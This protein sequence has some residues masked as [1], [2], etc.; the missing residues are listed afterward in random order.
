[1]IGPQVR[2]T[3][4]LLTLML[5]AVVAPSAQQ[6]SRAGQAAPGGQAGRDLL[7]EADATPTPVPR[8]YAV[9]VGVAHYEKLNASKQL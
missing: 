9:I 4:L 6:A 7:F 2:R 3:A 1:M 5:A 8:G